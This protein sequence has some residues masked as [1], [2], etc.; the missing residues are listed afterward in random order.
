[1]FLI[2]LKRMAV[3]GLCLFPL[4]VIIGCDALMD[5][6]G[7]D[8]KQDLEKVVTDIVDEAKE[9]VKEKIDETLP[10]KPNPDEDK[11]EVAISWA[12][13]WLDTENIYICECHRFVC[14]AYTH[15]GI[16]ITNYKGSALAVF[17]RHEDAIY[18][19]TPPRGAMILYVL[20]RDK[21]IPHTALSLGGGEMIHN[22]TVRC[23]SDDDPGYSIVETEIY[24]PSYLIYIG[25]VSLID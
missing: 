11:I 1:M 16:D 23:P 22:N 3:L 2:W 4:C 5:E 15:A 24:K 9:D 21:N 14:D 19:S 17:D 7:E 12:N 6:I 18:K 13:S 25:W 10:I 8:L 20:K